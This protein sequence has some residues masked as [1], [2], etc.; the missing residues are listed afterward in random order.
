MEDA[1]AKWPKKMTSDLKTTGKSGWSLG[2]MSGMSLDGIDAAL[3]RTD[4]TQILEFGPT[5]FMPFDPILKQSLISILGAMPDEARIIPVVR[6][7]T[8]ANIEVVQAL[9]ATNGFKPDDITVV[10]FHGQALWHKSRRFHGVGATC[11]VGDATWL[12][13]ATGINVVHQFRLADIEAGGEGAPLVPIYH[14]ALMEKHNESVMCVN[15][16]GIANVTWIGLAMNGQR[17]M[18]A[19][20]VGPGNT[21]IDQWVM[22]KASQPCDRG[23]EYALKG[24]VDPE[25]LEFLIAQSNFDLPPPKS[26]DRLNFTL[27]PVSHLSLENGA[28]TLTQLT[29]EGIVSSVNFVPVA[30]IEWILMGGGRHNFAILGALQERLSALVGPEVEVKTAEQIGLRGDFIEAEAFA[31]LAMRHLND[32]PFSFPSTT[33]VKAPTCGG[34]LA[35]AL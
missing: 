28:A 32:L 27:D 9:L 24:Q 22:K 14:Q 20:D 12:A 23:G 26:F 3:I 17:Q 16:G 10:G 7:Y 15:V 30:P 25:L 35:L 11:Q 6:E 1:I 18:I 19:F 21:L 34:Q 31:Y 8:K 2:L 4:G 13:Q 33:G 5:L 29:V